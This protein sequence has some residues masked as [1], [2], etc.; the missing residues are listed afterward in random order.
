MR[1][2]VDPALCAGHGMCVSSAERV[3][4][5]DEDGFNAA[6]GRETDVPP[7]LEDDAEAGAAACPEQAIRILSAMRDP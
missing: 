7:G 5:L 1:Y 4:T 6:A 2:L 3:Y